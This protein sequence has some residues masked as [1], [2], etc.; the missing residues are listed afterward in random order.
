MTTQEHP[1]RKTEVYEEGTMT[2][3]TEM[4]VSETRSRWH[5]SRVSW[6]AIFA[7]ALV[8]LVVMSVLNILGVAIGAAAIDVTAGAEGL[9]IGVGIWWTVTA[10][11]ALFIGGWT[12]GHFS[13]ADVRSDG[14]MHGVVTWSLFVMA[15]FLAVTTA[16]G[17]FLGGAFGFIS[18]NLAVAA[19]AMQPAELTAIQEGVDAAAVAEMEAALATVGQQAMDSLAIGAGWAFVALLLGVLVCALGGSFGIIEPGEKGEKRSKRFASRL[20]PRTA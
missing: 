13:E 1:S 10:L 7:G 2:G 15:S 5:L 19:A 9:G 3:G 20:R 12:A 18:Q 6:G 17:Q 16:V 8:A 4:R 11:I 14:L